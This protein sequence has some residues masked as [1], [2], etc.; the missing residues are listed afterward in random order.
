MNKNKRVAALVLAAALLMGCMSAFGGCG[1]P[2]EE[3][4]TRA[5]W[6]ILL[7]ERF[8]LDDY[9]T[10]EPVFSDVGQEE[11]CYTGLQSC[12]DWGIVSREASGEF[13]PDT[14]VQAEFAIETALLAAG[15][16]L[17]ESEAAEFAVQQGILENDGYAATKSRVTLQRAQEI[18]DW[19]VGLYLE[20]PF[21]EYTNV[22]L[23]E[24][25][26]D[27][28]GEADEITAVSDHV[29]LLSETIGSEIARGDIILLPGDETDPF[30]IAGKVESVEV[31]ED[32]SCQVTVSEPEIGEVCEELEIAAIAIPRAEDVILAEGVTWAKPAA[33]NQSLTDACYLRKLSEPEEEAALRD[34]ARVDG[35]DLE[36]SIN[37]TSQKLS[38][39]P[40]WDSFFGQ[41]ESV[42]VGGEFPYS[43]SSN[44]KPFEKES[45]IPDR[46]LFGPDPYDNTKDIEAYQRGDIT[47]DDLCARL[48]ETQQRKKD[49]E[50]ISKFTAGYEITGSVKLEDFY[51]Q[52][53]TKLDK[54]F[55]VPVGI[56]SFS[57]EVN[58]KV[59]ASLSIKG[60][61]KEELTIARVPIVICPGVTTHVNISL[62]A[63]MNGE[64][65]V[66]ATIENNT[67]TEYAKGKTKKA[68]SQSSSLSGKASVKLDA[69]PQLTATLR[70]LGIDI[71]DASVFLGIRFKGKTEVSL[72][73]DFQVAEDTLTITRE[74]HF[75]NKVEGFVP[76]VKL[77]IGTQGKTLAKKLKLSFTWEII[78]EKTAYRFDILPP[79]D[80]VIWCETL[81]LPK[82]PE[83]SDA[84]GTEES[85]QQDGDAASGD[86]SSYLTIDRYFLSL[87]LEGSGTIQIT[88][89]PEG[90]SETDLIWNSD[91][92]SVATV[93]AGHV[94]AV[95][96]GVAMITVR[97]ADGMYE[98]FCTVSVELPLESFEELKDL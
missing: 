18:L 48:G 93:S 13:Y 5:E 27:L 29:F 62:C 46:N 78:G 33:A 15:A 86:R 22:V 95:G 42:K 81:T 57:V 54:V 75:E 6:I 32:G 68:A 25:M 67:K 61:L 50:M 44:Y 74:T 85:G 72:N 36:F 66:K 37:L 82:N 58:S 77:K 21:E 52:L 76:I 12:A 4:L 94:T 55:G 34:A 35:L 90:Y 3:Y 96:S 97:S 2:K 9:T 30:G 10:E 40:Q 89:I 28:T 1:K 53:E 24:D 49:A 91:N 19:A 65:T 16:E 31:R 17:T 7:A 70:V 84:D 43:S 20:Q 8:G 41:G 59:E 69:G 26:I 23:K 14:E 56:K 87:G 45:T 63:E 92:P 64:I 47:L 60:K 98:A 73:T 38:I 88:G 83:K 39:T 11:D 51:L 80:E 79:I 71:L